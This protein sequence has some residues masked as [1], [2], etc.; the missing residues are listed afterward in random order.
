MTSMARL[1]HDRV[2]LGLAWQKITARYYSTSGE[3]LNLCCVLSPH[4]Y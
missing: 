3:R 1:S 4:L 2:V